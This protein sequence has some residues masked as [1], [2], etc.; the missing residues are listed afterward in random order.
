MFGWRGV[1]LVFECRGVPSFGVVMLFNG[2]WVWCGRAL[3]VWLFVRI[4]IM[5]L[6]GCIANVFLF[7]FCIGVVCVLR[8]CVLWRFCFHWT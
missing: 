8:V 5:G 1:F 4:Y 2:V 6:F 7:H 3:R